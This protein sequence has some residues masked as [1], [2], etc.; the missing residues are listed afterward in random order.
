MTTSQTKVIA[1]PLRPGFW[2][3]QIGDR[4][5]GEFD[6]YALAVATMLTR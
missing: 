3:I 1:H 4:I 6:R 2:T 5:Y